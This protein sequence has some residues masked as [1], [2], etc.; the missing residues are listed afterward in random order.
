MRLGHLGL[1]VMTTAIQIDNLRYSY[2]T[3]GEVISGLSL[4]INDKERI[5]LWG[6]NGSG[7]TTLFHLILG[8]LKPSSGR[9]SIYGRQC[10]SEKDFIWAR[11]RVGL[12]FQ[13]PNDQL[14]SPTV[15]ED[16]AFGPLNLG[17]KHD[18]VSRIVAKALEVV[19]LSGYEERVSYKLSS[20][21]KHLAALATVLAMEPKMLLLDE[22]MTGLDED[23]FD[24]VLSILTGLKIG[25]LIISH[26]KRVLES[27][28]NKILRMENGKIVGVL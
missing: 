18:E 26:N 24:R 28:S 6:P 8:L 9:L 23:A 25:F 11:R 13:D 17:K 21:E 4:V 14:F 7:K 15:G 19:G 5:G 27:A 22:P 2:P 16:V 20:G 10:K 12:L 1:D 3:G